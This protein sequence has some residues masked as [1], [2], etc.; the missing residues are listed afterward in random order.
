MTGRV[1]PQFP[2]HSGF[3]AALRSAVDR[4]IAAIDEPRDVAAMYV[5]IAVL[6]ACTIACY[7]VY[8]L[9]SGPIVLLLA[10]P[11]GLLL[12]SIGFNVMHDGGHESLSR[13]R[14]VNRCAAF[15]LDLL[16]GSS[17]VWRWKHNVYHHS[18]PNVG[19]VDSDIEMAPVGHLA[20]FQSRL[21]IHRYQHLYLWLLYGLLP[22][23]WHFLDDFRDVVRGRIGEMPLP[24]PR[25]LDLIVFVTGKAAFFTTT[26][27]V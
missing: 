7:A 25:G 21:W 24:R 27:V 2:P 15:S 18:Y 9:L 8:L 20:P 23:K 22:L 26:F 1:L 12:A 11:F 14:V 3:Y 6:G 17:Y 19:G 13:H 16:G 10:V 4:E 5:K